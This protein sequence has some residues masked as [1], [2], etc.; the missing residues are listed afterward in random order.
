MLVGN[1]VWKTSRYF[2]P[3]GGLSVPNGHEDGV[4]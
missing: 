2:R 4:N 3:L 1:Q